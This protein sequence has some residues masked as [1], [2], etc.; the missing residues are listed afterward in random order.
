MADGNVIERVTITPEMASSLLEHNTMNRPISDPHIK[1]IA[2]QIR[3]GKWRYNGDTIKL[4][5]QEDVLDGQQRLWAVVESNRSIDTIIVRGIAREAFATMDSIRRARSGGDTIARLGQGASRN[6]IATALTWM[7]RWQRGIMLK[8]R[9]PR[10]RIENSD[11]EDAFNQHPHI[12]EAVSRCK[13]FRSIINVGV[14]AFTYYILTNRDH[15]LADRML[16]TIENPTAIAMDDPFFRLRS[17]LT[18]ERSVKRRE[19][20]VVIAYIFKAANAVRAGKK[21]KGLF[22]QSQGKNAEPFPTLNF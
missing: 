15:A 4:S 1:R 19:P 13:K 11:I 16:N 8:F 22:W 17:F 18:E 10:N 2:A 6:E 20:L 3:D 5:E 21:I 9:D 14:L 7:M 12:V